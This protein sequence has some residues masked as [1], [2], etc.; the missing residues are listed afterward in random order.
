MANITLWKDKDNKIID[1]T[2]FSSKAETLAKDLAAE[3]EISRGRTNKRTQIRRFYDEVLR[4]DSEA[5]ARPEQ[6]DNILPRLHMLTAKAAYAKGRDLVS[7][8][9]LHF[10]RNSID[11]INHQDDLVVFANFFEAFM[12][13]YRLY[14]PAN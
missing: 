11:Q 9:F 10:I 12:G 2:L 8:Q 6:W 3:S 5:K 4:L 14:R 1:P 7:E 13:F